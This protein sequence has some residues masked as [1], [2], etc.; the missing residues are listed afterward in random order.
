[1]SNNVSFSRK[2]SKVLMS[3]RKHYRSNFPMKYFDTISIRAVQTYRHT[4]PHCNQTGTMIRGCIQGGLHQ[5]SPTRTQAVL[6]RQRRE[7]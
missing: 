1:M 4:L 3:T 6:E 5:L 7:C 2:A